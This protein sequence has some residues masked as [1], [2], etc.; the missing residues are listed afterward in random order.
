MWKFDFIEI[1]YRNDLVVF[2]GDILGTYQEIDEAGRLRTGLE[3]IKF[4]ALAGVCLDDICQ[5]YRLIILENNEELLLILDKIR[6][7]LY[8]IKPILKN[9]I[10]QGTKKC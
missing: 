8:L 1:S 5:L 3:C 7:P 2:T 4:F 6:S 9:N 10:R